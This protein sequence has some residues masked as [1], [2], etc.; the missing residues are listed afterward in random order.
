MYGSVSDEILNMGS[1]LTT[2]ATHTMAK[3]VIR[4]LHA[5][6]L[7]RERRREKRMNDMHG[8]VKGKGE[9]RRILR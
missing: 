5:C 6:T 1:I 2:H 7:G 8:G 9:E 4:R 3:E